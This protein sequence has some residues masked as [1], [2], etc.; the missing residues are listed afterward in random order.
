MPQATYT[1]QPKLEIDGQPAAEKLIED[2]LQ[3]SIEE[4]LHLPSMFTIV[5]QNSKHPGRANQEIWEHA[6]ALGMGKKIKLGFASSAT[7][8]MEFQEQKQGWLIVGEIT[9]I[10]T[11][12]TSGSQA[13]IIVR[14]YDR[15]HRLH[16]GTHNRSFQKM[17]D[18]NIVK[19]IIAEVG[20]S[21]STPVARYERGQKITLEAGT[22]DS[23]SPAHDYVFQENQT[24]MEFLRERAARNGYELFIQDDKLHFHKPRKENAL[25]MKWLEDLTS[26]RVRVSSAEQVREVEVRGWDYKQKQSIV[27]TANQETILTKT[28]YGKGAKISSEFGSSPKLTVVDQPIHSNKEAKTMADAL[29]HELS[30]EFVQADAQAQGNPQI[31]PGRVATL[32]GM[33]KYSGEYYITDTHH[34]FSERVYSTGFSVRG[35]RGGDL[36]SLLSPPPDRKLGRIC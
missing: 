13:P 23:T 1:A 36:L 25:S 14:G 34:R 31:R 20:L 8:A 21:G 28:E 35:L 32:Q 9:A 5:V 2:I 19:K 26:F 3:I 29:F 4:S 6:A 12:F 33:G 18:A 11:H 27:E 30:D 24:N 22:I 15:S 7:E 17:S 10:E 16:R